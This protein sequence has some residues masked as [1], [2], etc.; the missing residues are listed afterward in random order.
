MVRV[1]AA[2]YN[3]LEEVEQLRAALAKIAAPATRP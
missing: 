1:E 3:S 2:H